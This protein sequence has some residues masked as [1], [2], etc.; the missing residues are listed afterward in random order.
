MSAARLEFLADGGVRAGVLRLS[1]RMGEFAAAAGVQK[2]VTLDADGRPVFPKGYTIPR[3]VRGVFT[4][5]LVVLGVP[6]TVECLLDPDATWGEKNA[7][8]R[9]VKDVSIGDAKSVARDGEGED[10]PGVA[11]LPTLAPRPVPPESDQSFEGDE[12]EGARTEWSETDPDEGD[13]NDQAERVGA[14]SGKLARM[15]EA[16]KRQSTRPAPEGNGNGKANGKHR[17]KR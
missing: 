12:D 3:E 17:G 1:R 5:I 10:A 4:E 14:S 15:L 9:F 11:L 8:L 16:R 6:S 13:G 2:A 7:A